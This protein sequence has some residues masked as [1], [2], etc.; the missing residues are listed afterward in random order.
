MCISVLQFLCFH[1]QHRHSTSI[2]AV[3]ATSVAIPRERMASAP[4]KRSMRCRYFDASR[5]F[6]PNAIYLRATNMSRLRG[7]RGCGLPE[8]TGLIYVCFGAALGKNGVCQTHN[9]DS[10][11]I[12]R[13]KHA[14]YRAQHI[15]GIHYPTT[16]RSP[17]FG[18]GM[19]AQ[20]DCA[21]AIRCF[22]MRSLRELSFKHFARWQLQYKSPIS[23]VWF[24]AF[25]REQ[26]P[27]V[28]GGRARKR[29]AKTVKKV[30]LVARTDEIVCNLCGAS[31]KLFDSWRRCALLDALWCTFVVVGDALLN[32]VTC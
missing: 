32:W 11:P 18:A 7:T 10:R 4:H 8:E 28:R 29:T 12:R 19:N 24:L 5:T 21:R 27:S 16:M 1:P 22:S 26:L 13:A 2:S 20:S 3:A 17:L 25:R 30:N 9:S 14:G 15:D 31:R 23:H 6:C